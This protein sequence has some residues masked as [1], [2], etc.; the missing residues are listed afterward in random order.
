MDLI[1]D[2]HKALAAAKIVDELTDQPDC[3]DPEKAILEDRVAKLEGE[4]A[5]IKEQLREKTDA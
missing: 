3:H 2:F 4:L 5:A 1:K